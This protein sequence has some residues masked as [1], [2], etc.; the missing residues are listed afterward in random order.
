MDTRQFDRLGLSVK[1]VS[2]IEDD[3]GNIICLKGGNLFEATI[4]DISK[5]GMG[6]ITKCLLPAGLVIETEISGDAFGLSENIK[7]K[8]EIRYCRGDKPGTYKCGVKFLEISESGKKAIA[9]FISSHE[10]R[11]SPRIELK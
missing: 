10:R 6:L 11:Q 8:G 4:S 3:S 1:A 7:V 9:S 2:K 5:N